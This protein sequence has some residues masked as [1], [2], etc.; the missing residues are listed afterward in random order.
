[1]SNNNCSFG[2][3]IT[4][5]NFELHITKLPIS[6]THQL[7]IDVRDPVEHEMCH[8]IVG[9]NSGGW[10]HDLEDLGLLA[11]QGALFG[12]DGKEGLFVKD[13]VELF[14]ACGAVLEEVVLQ[15]GLVDE[16]GVVEGGRGL[17][18]DGEAFARVHV[19]VECREADDLGAQDVL[20]L[21]DE[22]GRLGHVTG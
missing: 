13:V 9:A 10:E 20:E 15:D 22:H 16:P 4:S 12:R 1:M 14:A 19:G 18:A 7:L 8:R 5:I 17:V 3:A 21:V 6:A 2:N 11:V